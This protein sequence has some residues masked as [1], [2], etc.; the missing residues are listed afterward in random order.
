MLVIFQTCAK[1]N[2]KLDMY[3]LM[4]I[5]QY[6][7][8]RLLKPT[9]VD[10]FSNHSKIPEVHEAN[11][12]CAWLRSIIQH[13]QRSYGLSSI[14]DNLVKLYENNISYIAQIE[15]EFIKGKI[16]HLSPLSSSI[17]LSSKIMGKL[18]FHKFCCVII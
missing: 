13:I 9:I 7:M 8:W 17:L 11:N 3:L 18:M 10:T 12:E 6:C 4:V 15:G 1:F 16:I 2:L 5:Q 14:Y